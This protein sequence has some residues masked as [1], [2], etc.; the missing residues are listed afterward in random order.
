MSFLVVWTESAAENEGTEKIRG[1]EMEK[2]E[3]QGT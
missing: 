2:T 3:S 1:R